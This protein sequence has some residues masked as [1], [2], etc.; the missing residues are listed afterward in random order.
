MKKKSKTI[1]HHCYYCKKKINRPVS[2]IIKG[3]PAK[4]HRRCRRNEQI[5]RPPFIR[6]ESG[7]TI[8]KVINTM[9]AEEG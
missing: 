7:R 4:V 5:E 8:G 2:V 1:T 3:V 6:E 9:T